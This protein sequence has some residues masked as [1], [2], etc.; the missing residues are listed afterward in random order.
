MTAAKFW[1]RNVANRHPRVVLDADREG[2]SA[3]RTSWRCLR[4]TVDVGGVLGLAHRRR[5]DTAEKRT[6]GEL[7]ERTSDELCLFLIAEKAVDGADTRAQTLA[8]V[9]VAKV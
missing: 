3:A 9:G 1:V 5:S 2:A 4:R 6:V 8:K 7:W